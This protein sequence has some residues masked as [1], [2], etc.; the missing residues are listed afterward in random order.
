[1]SILDHYDKLAEQRDKW[2]AKKQLLLP[3]AR[4][5]LQIPDP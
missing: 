1:M 5:F 4:E 2:K 3:G